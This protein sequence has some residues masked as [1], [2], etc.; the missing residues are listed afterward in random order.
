MIIAIDGPAASGKGTLGRRLAQLYGLAYLDTG[1]LYRAVGLALL[2]DNP[3]SG[4]RIDEHRAAVLAR[5]LD[6]A[7]LHD[8]ALRDEATGAAARKWRPFP[9][10]AR[11]FWPFSANLRKK[12]RCLMVGISARWCAPMPM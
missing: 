11:R 12:G 8:P 6:V 1:S 4:D 7:T 2:R 3:A 10:C 9:M 5:D